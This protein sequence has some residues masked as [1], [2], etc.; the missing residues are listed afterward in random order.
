MIIV[1]K[2]CVCV[3]LCLSMCVTPRGVVTDIAAAFLLVWTADSKERSAENTAVEVAY[4]DRAKTL[5]QPLCM[6]G[7]HPASWGSKV[8]SMV[9]DEEASCHARS[10]RHCEFIS[11]S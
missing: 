11:P 5:I 2:A 3:C 6:K 10:L 7:M 9:S 1:F 8:L 4:N